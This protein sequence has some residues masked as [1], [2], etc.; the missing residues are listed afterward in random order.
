MYFLRRNV[1]N[2]FWFV[3]IAGGLSYFIR[4]KWF[5]VDNYRQDCV[6]HVPTG[7]MWDVIFYFL[8]DTRLK[9]LCVV[10]WTLFLKLE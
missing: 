9:K 7:K 4:C 6:E 2:D 10:E 3:A 8:F 1:P 5:G